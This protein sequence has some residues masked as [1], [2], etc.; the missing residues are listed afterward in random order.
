MSPVRTTRSASGPFSVRS[1]SR[2]QSFAG[3]PVAEVGTR[4]GGAAADSVPGADAGTSLPFFN[5]HPYG[6]AG[7]AP[8]GFALESAEVAADPLEAPDVE[9]A[10]FRSAERVSA[11]RDAD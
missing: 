3:S 7:L 5:V 6:A 11:R 10:P 2:A 1:Y 9:T 8:A 4:V